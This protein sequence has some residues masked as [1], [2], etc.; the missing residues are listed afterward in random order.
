MITGEGV[1]RKSNILDKLNEIDG[2][3]RVREATVIKLIE[4]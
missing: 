1:G 2:V 3:L 4:D